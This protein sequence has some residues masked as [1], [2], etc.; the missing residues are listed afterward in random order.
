MPHTE[1][2]V[3]FN[4]TWCLEHTE[5]VQVGRTLLVGVQGCPLMP[6]YEEVELEV[7]ALNL[8]KVF[9]RGTKPWTMRPPMEDSCT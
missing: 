7:S 3:L 6:L 8:R 2:T 4:S 9:P 5:E 1:E